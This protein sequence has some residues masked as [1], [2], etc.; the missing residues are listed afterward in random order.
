MMFIYYYHR[1][2]T[3]K[4]VE[5]TWPGVSLRRNLMMCACHH[6]YMLTAESSASQELL[7]HQNASSQLRR[8]Y[9]TLAHFIPTPVPEAL[10]HQ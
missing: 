2:L 7:G 9:S 5:S 4:N 1:A 6:Q 3:Q 10:A 8:P